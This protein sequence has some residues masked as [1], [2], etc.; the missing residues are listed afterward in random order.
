MQFGA[1]VVEAGDAA[2]DVA[3][4]GGVAAGLD[5]EVTEDVD[6]LAG[7]GVLQG[8]PGRPDGADIADCRAV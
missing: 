8:Y 6:P 3:G 7:G 5:P 1:A 2:P 4:L